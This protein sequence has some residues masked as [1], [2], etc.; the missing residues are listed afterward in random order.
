MVTDMATAMD[1]VTDTA[2]ERSKPLLTSITSP[3][4]SFH[5]NCIFKV[6]VH[7]RPKPFF[8]FPDALTENL[9]CL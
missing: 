9:Q 3:Q 2:E 1:M 5:T 6:S 4:T 8:V 7:K